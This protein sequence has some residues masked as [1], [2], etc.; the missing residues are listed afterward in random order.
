MLQRHKTGL[1]YRA[2]VIQYDS[3]KH[4]VTVRVMAAGNF[5][6]RNEVKDG[7]SAVGDGVAGQKIVD[8]RDRVIAWTRSHGP[9][10]YEDWRDHVITER[11]GGPGPSTGSVVQLDLRKPLDNS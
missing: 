7:G 6:S 4:A 11:V 10:S 1:D 5:P 2:R 9:Y 8:W 3:D